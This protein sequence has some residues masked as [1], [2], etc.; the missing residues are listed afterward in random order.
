MNA[1]IKTKPIRKMFHYTHGITPKRVTN[2]GAHIRS[3][4]SGLHS[5]EETSQRGQTVG[6]IVSGLTDPGFKPP[7]SRTDSSVITSE[8]T[9]W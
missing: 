2:G 4:A 3:L 7:I 9:G 8:L 1:S 5:Y 6:G